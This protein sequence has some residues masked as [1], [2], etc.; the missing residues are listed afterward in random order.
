[1]HN[2]KTSRG[3]RRGGG[4][5]GGPLEGARLGQSERIKVGIWQGAVERGA[6]EGGGWWFGE[7]RKLQTFGV[8]ILG[9]AEV[10]R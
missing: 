6:G 5:G 9:E 2:Y 10:S 4:E 8:W 7:G 1:M 3:W